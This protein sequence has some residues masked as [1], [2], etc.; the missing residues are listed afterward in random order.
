VSRPGDCVSYIFDS[1]MLQALRQM[2]LL[3]RGM[4]DT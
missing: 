3:Q 1:G 4:L 2:E